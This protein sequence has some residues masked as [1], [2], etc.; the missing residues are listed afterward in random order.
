VNALCANET[1]RQ[2][3][4][5]PLFVPRAEEP[6]KLKMLNLPQHDGRYP[7]LYLAGA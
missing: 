7:V 5:K 6:M 2:Q 3:Q 1:R 4:S